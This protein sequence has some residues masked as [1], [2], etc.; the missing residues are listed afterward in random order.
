MANTTTK[1]Q[2]VADLEKSVRLF[3]S[4]YGSACE[5]VKILQGKLEKCIDLAFEANDI[6]FVRELYEDIEIPVQYEA[7]K[8]EYTNK[9]GHTSVAYYSA[10][11][12]YSGSKP[13]VLT[14]YIPFNPCDFH[15]DMTTR[16]I[17]YKHRLIK[18]KFIVV[19][20]YEDEE[21]EKE[22]EDE[23]EESEDEES[24]DEESDEEA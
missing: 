10:Y 21:E 16:K 7:S 22:D 17:Q 8:G 15:I 5:K 19:D 13:I 6:E 18:D 4:R 14:Y 20:Y 11:D 24:E 12:K 2:T 9:K 23:D 1:T 3:K